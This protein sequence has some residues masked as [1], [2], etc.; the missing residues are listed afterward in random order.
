MFMHCSFRFHSSNSLL[1]PFYFSFYPLILYLKCSRSSVTS[2][3]F[4]SVV[5][6][7]SSVYLSNTAVFKRRLFCTPGAKQLKTF[8]VVTIQG[9]CEGVESRGW[10]SRL[11]SSKQSPGML[12]NFSQSKGH[13]LP[14]HYHQRILWPQ[15]SIVLSLRNPSQYHLT[16][17]I[18]FLPLYQRV[19]HSPYFPPTSLCALSQY[20]L[21]VPPLLPNFLMFECPRTWY[22]TFFFFIYT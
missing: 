6:S 17:L 12:L 1:K 18:D 19:P 2:K 8:L 10:Q 16:H 13:S 4:I 15:M 14:H 21:L 7:Q 9:I 5:N 22:F 20:L 11:A 3:S